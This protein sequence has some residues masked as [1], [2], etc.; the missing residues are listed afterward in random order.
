MF[1]LLEGA[2]VYAVVIV[3]TVEAI[4]SRVPSLDGWRVLVVAAGVAL[5][6]GALFVPSPTPQA[7]LETARIA[8]LSWV[9]AVGG[10]AWVARIASASRLT[11]V[12]DTGT[13]REAPTVKDRPTVPPTKEA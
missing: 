12:V 9:I 2:G 13:W 10:N 7:I 3:A 8:A 1:D 5:L 6:L 11:T 4:R